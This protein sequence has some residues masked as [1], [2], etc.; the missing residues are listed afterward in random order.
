M[1]K[2]HRKLDVC[3]TVL[4]AKGGGLQFIHSLCKTVVR[5]QLR[6]SHNAECRMFI[7]QM[8][9]CFGHDEEEMYHIEYRPMCL[10]T[11]PYMFHCLIS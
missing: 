1:R 5:P 10:L 3:Y 11:M 7:L 6:T 8:S 4:A 9:T 2:L